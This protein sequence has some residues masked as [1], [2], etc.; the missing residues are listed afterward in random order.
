MHDTI[1]LRSSMARACCDNDNNI[2]K[3]FKLLTVKRI[4]YGRGHGEYVDERPTDGGG[5]AVF[6]TYQR[7]RCPK[8]KTSGGS[9]LVL[10]QRYHNEPISNVYQVAGTSR[11]YTLILTVKNRN[12][13]C[14]KYTTYSIHFILRRKKN[15]RQNSCWK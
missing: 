10:D 4:Q 3:Q 11:N 14:R 2:I 1:R 7:S 13:Y 15:R 12:V 5:L 6:A 9:L 8:S